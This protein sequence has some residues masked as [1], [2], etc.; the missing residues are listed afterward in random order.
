MVQ[1]NPEQFAG[2]RGF[3]WDVVLLDEGHKLKNPKTQLVQQ[4]VK[5]PS[6]VR[7]IIT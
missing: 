4:L 7:V 1:H 5:L 3:S 2:A 6:R